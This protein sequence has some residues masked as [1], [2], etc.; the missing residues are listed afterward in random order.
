MHLLMQMQLGIGDETLTRPECCICQ[1][2]I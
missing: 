2:H 1:R